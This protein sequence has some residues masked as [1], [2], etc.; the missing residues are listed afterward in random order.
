MKNIYR[1]FLT[2]VLMVGIVSANAQ[3]RQPNRCTITDGN[4]SYTM[5]ASANTM[6]NKVSDKI[7]STSF[8]GV[9]NSTIRSNAVTHNL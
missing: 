7:I 1:M 8:G 6:I 4:R 2:V 9:E 3:N 5:E